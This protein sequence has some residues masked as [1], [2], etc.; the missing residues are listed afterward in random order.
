MVKCGTCAR[1][2]RT[3]GDRAFRT[4]RSGRAQQPAGQRKLIRLY[5]S[6]ADH[7]THLRDHQTTVGIRPHPV[8]GLRKNEGEFGLI[9]LIYNFRRVI[10]ILGLP[11]LKKWLRKLLFFGLTMG[12]RN[13]WQQLNYPGCRFGPINAQVAWEWFWG[14][15]LHE[16]PLPPYVRDDTVHN[17]IL[18][19]TMTKTNFAENGEAGN[20]PE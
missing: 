8:K 14:G 4:C 20:R 16:L 1:A 13:C 12:L 9:Y 5:T 15:L 7:R 18:W 19:R 11:K 17:D 6:S 10:N 3:M 2:I